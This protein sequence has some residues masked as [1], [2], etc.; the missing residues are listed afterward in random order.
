MYVIAKFVNYCHAHLLFHM[1]LTTSLSG[2]Q[3]NYEIQ[4]C[5]GLPTFLGSP[6][7]WIR[8]LKFPFC[9]VHADPP[10]GSMNL[11]EWEA[12]GWGWKDEFCLGPLWGRFK[13]PWS[14]CTAPVCCRILPDLQVW[15]A[16][17]LCC[18]ISSHSSS[19]Q[20]TTHSRL[21]CV[22]E[23]I[24]VVG[25]WKVIIPQVES[26]FN[27]HS[28]VLVHRNLLSTFHHWGFLIHLLPYCR[29]LLAAYIIS[30][31]LSSHFW[32]LSNLVPWA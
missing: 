19:W 10:H 26:H 16:S 25:K 4:I 12:W 5:L 20:F 7:T 28:D 30:I 21:L 27:L 29:R 2:S 8:G 32:W 11:Q 31:F 3:E 6:S 23:L 18:L 17:S 14:A 15:Y 24:D 22:A 9:A 13:A 1:V